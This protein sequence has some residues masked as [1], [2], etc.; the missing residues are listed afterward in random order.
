MSWW[1]KNK[2][3]ISECSEC[4]VEIY[5]SNCV[6]GNTNMCD[7]CYY[8]SLPKVKCSKCGVETYEMRLENG[9][10]GICK[11]EKETGIKSEH[12]RI[13]ECD[14]CGREFV[15]TAHW[16]MDLFQDDCDECIAKY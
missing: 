8:S 3:D 12:Q 4:G 7:H 10:C 9:L 13:A 14:T 5:S 1:N 2:H 15:Y 11:F 16:P 6:D